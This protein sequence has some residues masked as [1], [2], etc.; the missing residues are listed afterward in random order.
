MS[1]SPKVTPSLKPIFAT[2]REQSDFMRWM[3]LLRDDVWELSGSLANLSALSK[4]T[5]VDEL[6]EV[7]NRN[8]TFWNANLLALETSAFVIVGRIHYK[9]ADAY[10]N[11][12]MKFLKRQKSLSSIADRFEGLLRTHAPL[13][14]TT[15]RLRNNVFAHTG[16][17][18]P[19]HVA[20]GFKDLAWDQFE[21]YWRDLAS[22]A[23]ALESAIFSGNYGP[24]CSPDRFDE[25][26]KRAGDAWD[27]IAKM[28]AGASY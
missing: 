23:E 8:P 18:S 5:E 6:L 22:I 1:W 19:E 11:C 2:S 3:R 7:L 16:E 10:L 25:D 12:I 14:G 20:F 17:T 4:R 26:L 15:L 24:R 21:V 9:G 27:V 28:G 13:I